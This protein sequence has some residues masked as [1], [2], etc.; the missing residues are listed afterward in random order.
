MSDVLRL[1][2]HVHSRCSP[3]T[4]LPLEET[5]GRLS[6]GGLR[7]FALT[8]HNSVAGHAALADLATKYTAY[9]FLPGV[10]VSTE[11][12]HLL[13]FGVREVP[14]P[15]R[16]VEETIDWVRAHGGEA[17]LAHPF[18]WV[19]GVGRA[20]AESAVVPALEVRNGHN[21]E[22]ANLKA[23]QVAA[24]RQL[25]ATGG[26]DAHAL[27]DLGRAYTEF[28]AQVATVDDVLEAIRKGA[29]QAGGKSMPLGGRVR[30]AIRSG[31]LRA[32]RGFRP[33]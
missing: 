28:D 16:G 1:D 12:G 21:S 15:H 5:V 20:L 32:G 8:D 23:E 13:A 10:E 18:R 17:V 27:N 26:S 19:H 11:Q 4:K 31:L 14:P 3:D 29:V 6:Y 2:L 33:V 9:L 24:R 22:V 30:L 7:G 25:G